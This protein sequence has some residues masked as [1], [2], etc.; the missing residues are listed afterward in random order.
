MSLIHL[1]DSLK[2]FNK[3]IVTG[4]QRSGTTI[5]MEILAME[6]NYQALREET[7]DTDNVSLLANILQSSKFVLQAPGLCSMVH[8]LR[9]DDTAI[10][11]IKREVSDIIKSEHRINW[12]WNE[13]YER[14]K[15]F[16]DTFEP[17]SHIK[18]RNWIKFQKPLLGNR[19]FE[20]DYKHLAGHGLFIAERE[21]FTDRQTSL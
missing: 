21:G 19:A 18:Y 8:L 15:Y 16:N 3:I 7:I 1:V 10:V 6:L 12:N 4:A 11:I 13:N 20:L 5:A 2:K 9:A 17:I 14:A